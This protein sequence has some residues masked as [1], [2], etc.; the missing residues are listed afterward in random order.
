MSDDTR[1]QINFTFEEFEALAAYLQDGYPAKAPE[2][3]QQI[4]EAQEA[5]AADVEQAVVERE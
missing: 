1:I 3:V 2:I 4:V 5:L